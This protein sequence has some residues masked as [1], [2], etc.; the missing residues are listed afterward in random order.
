MFNNKI[1]LGAI[2]GVVAT[3]TKDILNQGLYSLGI[4]KTL[5]AQ[6]A[7]GMYVSPQEAKVL[8]GILAGYLVDFG[9][10]ALLGIIFIGVI[11]KTKPKH[12]VFQGFLFG[13]AMYMLIYGA[14][15]S[16][17]ISSVKERG[18]IDVTLMIACHLAYGLT[19]GLMVR[20]FGKRV[21]EI[22]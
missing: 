9:L 8:P 15:L 12:L 10:S 1:Y 2:S 3:L 18:L 7:I 22:I 17:G 19:L 11:E 6:Y 14:L 21:L 13:S 5:F 20:K 4:L 16:F